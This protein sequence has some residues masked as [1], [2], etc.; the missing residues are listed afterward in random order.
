MPFFHQEAAAGNVGGPGLVLR[1]QGIAG[2][3]DGAGSFVI[4][5]AGP[6]V[7]GTVVEGADIVEEAALA[8]VAED[9]FR[10]SVVDEGAVDMGWTA[11]RVIIEG[12]R[13]CEIVLV[14]KG[15]GSDGAVVDGVAWG[16][17]GSFNAGG[18]EEGNG[19]GGRQERLFHND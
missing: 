5:E 10:A 9:K 2:V 11:V 7:G 4:V 15:H 17:E 19:A 1:G 13:I 14:I 12:E 8:V 6:E 16:K 3:D 18:K